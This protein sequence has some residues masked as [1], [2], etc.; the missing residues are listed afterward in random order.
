MMITRCYLRIAPGLIAQAGCFSV[1]HEYTYEPIKD[2]GFLVRD[3][4]VVG[5]KVVVIKVSAYSW[6]TI[7]LC[8]ND[9]TSKRHG[10]HV[11]SP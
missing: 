2:V 9:R 6:S 5:A 1:V 8:C 7:R 10:P 11:E 3:E 4:K